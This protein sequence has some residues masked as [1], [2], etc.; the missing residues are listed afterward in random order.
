[1]FLCEHGVRDMQDTRD[2][3]DVQS[4]KKLKQVIILI[5]IFLVIVALTVIVIDPFYHYHKPIGPLKAVLNEKEYQCIGTLRNFE[6]DAVIAG[7]SVSENYNNGWFDDGFD[8][9]SV[10]AIRSYGATADLCYLLDEAFTS[11]N[12]IRYV[13]YNL[14]PSALK[15]D[16]ETTFEASGCPMYLYDHNPFNDVQYLFNKD[17][18]MERIP[19]MVAKSLLEDYDEGTAYNWGQWKEFNLAMCTGLYLR[20]P[21]VEPMKESGYYD[22]LLYA[23][24]ELIENMVS[25][26]PET[27]FYIYMPPYSMLWWDN[28]YREGD[29][30][31]YLHVM[32]ACMERLAALDNV[33]FYYFMDDRDIITNLESN[34]MDTLHFSPDINY[35][36]YEALKEDEEQY[37]VTPD[38]IDEHIGKMQILAEEITDE[39]MEPYIPMIKEQI[40]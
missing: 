31:F 38:N 1:M 24:I 28:A 9:T 10:K 25:A 26:H 18:I 37:R 16:T 7:S 33:R 5:T 20:H 11:G 22:D 15:S 21:N 2:I 36:I 14:D 34:Y 13:F 8:C 32:E 19:Y 29:T 12:F 17:V 6:Y 39:L 4:G 35:H 30:R 27:V 40:E 23:N 3:K